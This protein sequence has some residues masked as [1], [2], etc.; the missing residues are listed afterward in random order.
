MWGESEEI[1]TEKL[2]QMT[3]LEM[4]IKESLR[5]YPSVPIISRRLGEDITVGECN[6]SSNKLFECSLTM[7]KTLQKKSLQ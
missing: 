3:Y 1:T 6:L 7:I 5:L 2:Q 4:V